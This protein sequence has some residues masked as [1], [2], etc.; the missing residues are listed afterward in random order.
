MTNK[1]TKQTRRKTAK[2]EL[3]RGIRK[4]QKRKSNSLDPD[5]FRWF[6]KPGSALQSWFSRQS[7]SLCI[8]S[9]MLE[10]VCTWTWVNIYEY[11]LLECVC[12]HVHVCES[13][14]VCVCHSALRV[15]FVSQFSQ[16]EEGKS[17]KR[18][19]F[20]CVVAHLICTLKYRSFLDSTL[21]FLQYEL[22]SKFPKCWSGNIKD[23]NAF[24]Y[25]I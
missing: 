1:A 4:D 11:A 18:I 13:E 19:K 10:C 20:L 3:T 17:L 23:S 15:L 24:F 5:S 22:L 7:L 16:T 9:S 2:D 6:M 14:C 25:N 8:C 12:T 21:F